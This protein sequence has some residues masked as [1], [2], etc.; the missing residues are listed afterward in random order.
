VR[1][2]HAQQKFS[3]IGRQFRQAPDRFARHAP[4]VI[5]PTRP[6]P[7]SGVADQGPAAAVAY[8]KAN[9]RLGAEAIAP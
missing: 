1:K 9:H 6:S 4:R 7:L 2:A 8:G 5:F 3:H